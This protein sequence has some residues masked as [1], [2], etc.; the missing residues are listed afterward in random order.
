M[1]NELF[2][3]IVNREE[4]MGDIKNKF[5]EFFFDKKKYWNTEK[6]YIFENILFLKEEGVIDINKNIKDN[7][8]VNNEII[9]P[10]LKDVTS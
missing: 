10:V 1:A 7:N 3:I 8:L 9:I 5:L 4:L 2:E 6:K